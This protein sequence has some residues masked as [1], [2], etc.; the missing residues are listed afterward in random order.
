MANQVE[1]GPAT[2]TLAAILI[3]QPADSSL[4]HLPRHYHRL[5][6]FRG[7]FRE[8]TPILTYHAIE[9]PPRRTQFRGLFYS[10]QDFAQQLGELKR[11]GFRTVAPAETCAAA[12][13]P[14]VA[15]TFDDGFAN[16]SRHAL[17]PLAEN[18]F[19]ATVFLVAVMFGKTNEWDTPAGVTAR[20]LMDAAQVRE[21]LAAGHRIGSHTLTHPHLPRISPAQAREE[22][23][24]SKRKLE[25]RF[26]VPVTDLCYPYGEWT[27]RDATLAAEAGYATA[28]TTKFGLNA[29]ATGRHALF[30]L[31][32]RRPT[33]SWKTFRQWLLRNYSLLLAR[34]GRA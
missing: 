29:A 31:T 12:G 26:G 4:A 25:D 28:C 20:P 22:I 23:H 16:L 9:H 32:V 2:V 14:R 24:A 3:M 11:A 13:E 19:S 34:P 5:G 15:L 21:W 17:A 8:G 1:F 18:Q 7:Y 33:R 6:A 27:E 30:R 10:P